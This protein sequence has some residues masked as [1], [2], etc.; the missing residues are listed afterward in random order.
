[1]AIVHFRSGKTECWVIECDVCGSWATEGQT[2]GDA[3]FLAVRDSFSEHEKRDENGVIVDIIDH[4]S[5]CTLAAVPPGDS[6]Q[7]ISEQRRRNFDF[8]SFR[9]VRDPHTGVDRILPKVAP[10][11]ASRQR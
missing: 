4:C 7:S 3:S 2:G 9:R 5:T 10:E 8:Y 6:P 11:G 1:M